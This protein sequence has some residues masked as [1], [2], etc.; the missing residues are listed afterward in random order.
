M[1]SPHPG[2]RVSTPYKRTNPPGRRYWSLGW[3]TGDD[4]PT[5][6]GTKAYAMTD[7]VVRSVS[8]TSA[9]GRQVVVEAVV[10][11][12]RFRWSFNH[13]SAVSV[14]TGQRVKAGQVLAR[15]GATG[16]VTGPHNHVE[17]RVAPYTFT[18]SAFRNPAALYA[19]KAP[20][21][22][23]SWTDL[24]PKVRPRTWYRIASQN[25]GGSND[26][27]RT[28][29]RTRYPKIVADLAKVDPD[30]VCV[31]ELPDAHLPYFDG[32]MSKAGFTRA[33]RGREGRHIYLTTDTV[34]K[35]SDAFDLRPRYRGDDKW[36]AYAVA[37]I[38]GHHAVIVS[39]HLEHEAGADSVRVDQAQSQ[40]AQA[41]AVAARRGLSR[42]RIVHATDTNSNTWVREKAFNDAHYVDAAETAWKAVRTTVGTFKGWAKT[43]TK[44]PR[45]DTI[46]VHRARPITYYATRTA[47]VGT[48]RDHLLI[49]AD[50]GYIEA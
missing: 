40:I 32:L 34:V 46:N 25:L 22:L 24:R 1:T 29:Y 35:E 16:N 10:D 5:P 7:G 43:W 42:T 27:G 31:Q 14:K 15:T 38:K 50:V 33:P 20:R 44:G 47:N 26:H 12:V 28:T 41:E 49:V 37:V 36:A 17:A 39:S 30:V 19:W 8:T 13:L 21:R 11:G 4:W 45:I 2:Y 23:P 6:T 9:Y 48:E 3:H 18:A